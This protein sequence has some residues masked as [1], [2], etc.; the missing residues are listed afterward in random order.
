MKILVTGATGYIG[1]RLVPVL[2]NAGH[3]VRTTTSDPDRPQ[4]WWSDRVETVTMNVLDDA[5]VDRACDGVDAVYYLIHGMGGEDF[6]ENDRRAARHMVAA[7]RRRGVDRVVYLSGTVPAV[8]GH[9]LSEH[10]S[11][12][13]EV[14][15]ILSGAPATVI[16]LRAAVIL[17]S[18]STS[19]EI[20]RQV[21]ERL[22]VRT[23]PDW[24]RS[25]VQP[26]AVVDV[27]WALLGALTIPGPT[28]HLD[29]G[30]PERLPYPSLLDRYAQIAGL[31]RPEV[32]VPLVPSHLVGL[33]LAGLTDV[34]GSTV[35]AL[36]ESLRH[37][38]VCAPGSSMKELLPTGYRLIGLEEAIRRSL[39]EN[40]A[41]P[42]GADPMGPLPHDPSWAGGGEEDKPMAAKAVDTLKGLF[43]RGR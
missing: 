3:D 14:E 35:R 4:P 34:P 38:M 2:L 42:E 16:T 37:D 33:L 12:R 13:L 27:L 28:R 31:T 22:P 15:R 40:D 6:A 9:E 36:V 18:G 20:I 7:V 32:E 5:E 41:A 39:S 11:S 17:G 19:F 1:G 25:D 21:S 43:P 24:M 29:I 10:I 8:P 23:V 30:G 26:I